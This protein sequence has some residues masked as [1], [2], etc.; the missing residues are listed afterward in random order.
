METLCGT[1]IKFLSD[2][3]DRVHGFVLDGGEAI[4]F[5]AEHRDLL[6]AIVKLNSKIEIAGQLVSGEDEPQLLE[7]A[8]FTNLDSNRST[9]LPIPACISKPG[10]LSDV[11]PSPMASLAA[12][13]NKGA[14]E[15]SDEDPQPQTSA[16]VIELCDEETPSEP[17]EFLSSSYE[18]RP[19]HP[20]SN[21]RATRSDATSEIERAYD[22]LHRIQAILAYLKIV[23]RQVH[24]M[25]QMHGEAQHTYEQALLR[26]SSEDFEGALE[27]ATASECLSRVVEGII[28]RTLRTDTSY[29]SLVSPPPEHTSTSEGS[30]GIQ[31]DLAT[32][33]AILLRVHWL[34]RN[35]TLPVEDRTQVRKITAWSDAFY[36][37]ASRMYRHGSREDAA[38][39]AQAAVDAAESAEHI[40]RNWYVAHAAG[41]QNYVIPTD[42]S[43][44]A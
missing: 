30:T 2:A 11:P 29:P 12:L 26:H 31:H 5:S 9:N 34:L 15:S 38:E 35:G 10:M 18:S 16:D 17:P 21:S 22:S 27:F 3:N 37:Q 43:V 24:G 4:L 1:V 36:H 32:V 7:A 8:L 40:C 28:S 25:S 39:L 6:A 20:P 14:E 33:E 42:S 41:S 23:K 19:Q 13:Q 44:R